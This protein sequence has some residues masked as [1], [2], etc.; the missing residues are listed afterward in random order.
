MLH[1][2]GY[3]DILMDTMGR[4]AAISPEFKVLQ[5]GLDEIT[6]ILQQLDNL[7]ENFKMKRP[8]DGKVVNVEVN[9]IQNHVQLEA[10]WGKAQDALRE[11]TAAVAPVNEVLRRLNP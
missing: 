7:Q 5:E 10:F 3:P 9:N 2:N 4:V 11:L 1:L 6:R 8:S